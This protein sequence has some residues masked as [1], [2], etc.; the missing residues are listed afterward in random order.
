MLHLPLNGS[1]SLCSR[2]G[3]VRVAASIPGCV[4]TDLLAANV[5]A[6]PWYRDNE[7][8]IHQVWKRDWI[9]ER[10]FVVDEELLSHPHIFLRCQGLDTLATVQIN[11]T[12]VLEAD[13]MHRTREAELGGV[14][15]AGT[16]TI[17]IT[18]TSPRETMIRGDAR[19]R[20]PAW[21]VFH[22]DF[23]GKSYVRKMAC[24]FGWDWGLMAPTA[25]IW[26]PVEIIAFRGRIRDLRIEQHHTDGGVTVRVAGCVEGAGKR[27]LVGITRHDR[28]VASAE[29][30]VCDGTFAGALAIEEPRLWW[31]NGLGDQPLYEIV[32]TL[33]S[34]DAVLH[35]LHRRIGLRCL[36]LIREQDKHGESFRFRVNG[37]DIFVKGAN[38]IPCDIF[39]SRVSDTTY[40]RLLHSAA[41]CH[42]NMI[43]VW[44][45][46][47]YEDDR[48][49]DLCDELGLLVW[50]DFMFACAAYPAYDEAFCANVRHEAIDT[51]TRLRHRPCLALWCGNNELEQ[52][53]VNRDEDAWTDEKMSRSD[54]EAL[55]DRVLAE[56]VEEH[57]GSTPYR[58]SSPHTPGAGRFGHHDD[59]RGDAHS[60]SVWFG[61][62]SFE[63][64][65]Q[66]RFRFISECGFQSFPEPRTVRSYT[67]PEDRFLNGWV[68]DF[69]QRSAPGNA[70]IY[71]YLLD[72]FAP[73]ASFEDTLWMTQIN[74]ALCVQYA[75]EHARRMQG[76][77][78]GLLYWQ[79]NDLWPGATWSS[80]DVFGRWKALQFF[81]RRFFAP[82]LV[83][84][85]ESP[86]HQNAHIHVSNHLLERTEALV[87][88]EITDCA[89]K[90]I[91]SGH[92]AVDIGGQENRCILT[93]DLADLRAGSPE[94]PLAIRH[95][96]HRP[97][98]A[99]RNLLIWARLE[100]DGDELSR[101]LAFLTRPRYLHL[102]MPAVSVRL[103]RVEGR[104]AWLT[105][106][107]DVPAPWTR[108][109]LC[110]IEGDFSDNFLHL[111]PRHPSRIRLHMHS[112][113]EPAKV[114]SAVRAIPLLQHCRCGTF[115]SI[116][117]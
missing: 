5:I 86:V 63:A 68:M 58:P 16:N 55:F 97:R 30:S 67:A 56:V 57:D 33:A 105:L 27:V 110:G 14:L 83:S 1:W 96:P 112:F 29:T 26:R 92:R 20:M 12:I 46:G 32:V 75:A 25:G 41:A 91:R 66:W 54:Y 49:Y 80:I 38:W 53:F 8:A 76:R 74:Q 6:D 40:S 78:D 109:E 52:G 48:F 115:I 69:H 43:R 15:H 39:P 64:Q 72:W 13:N 23:R 106:T 51:V 18:F 22:E 87:H 100:K 102:R 88:W 7:T 95:T 93:L 85:V 65:R 77:I 114:V 9:Y 108:V 117:P 61:G 45:G 19:R 107:T 70:T 4:H 44:G 71:R 31:P 84:I 59:S 34:D 98:E 103:E 47:I 90:S 82:L 35:T 60:W 111:H 113:T 73:P 17:R 3:E 36:A 21:N 94:L 62:Q 81:A 2:E 116:D 10:T 11:Q 101:N 89:G 79:L 37:R 104:S 99:D 42:M 50:Q 28:T 24:A